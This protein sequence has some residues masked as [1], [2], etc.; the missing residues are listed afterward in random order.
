[1]KIY[2]N[3]KPGGMGGPSVFVKNFVEEV[4]RRGH[5]V[6]YDLEKDCDVALN[7][8]NA[9]GKLFK[10][11][12]EHNIKTVGRLDGFYIP[13]YWNNQ[14]KHHRMT[15]DKIQTNNAMRHDLK[16]Y[17]AVIYQSEWSKQMFNRWISKRT[18]NVHVIHNGVN[19]KRFKPRRNRKK[20][21]VDTVL[22]LGALRHEYM[23]NTFFGAYDVLNA[24]KKRFNWLIAG[25]MDGVSKK[26]FSKYAG[27]PNVKYLGPFDNRLLPDI[28]NKA[29][30]FFHP[31]AGDSCPNVVLEAMACGLGVV[32]P[33]WGGTAELVARG[34]VIVQTDKWS[35]NKKYQADC[36]EAIKQVI[37]NHELH[38]F[39][40]RKRIEKCHTIRKMVDQYLEVMKK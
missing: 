35:Y 20:V 19:E 37:G 27:R 1:M 29:D 34:G 17:D 16:H 10:F 23:L 40:A 30:V 6:T 22:M 9:S 39:K 3:I 31:R 13:E 7:L 18:E 32:C 24:K 33:I 15:L 2:I 14:D 21:K 12:K 4:Q 38:T 36:A 8:V 26:I 11:C 25:T 28:Y 5:K